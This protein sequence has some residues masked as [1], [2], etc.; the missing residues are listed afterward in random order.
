MPK[1]Y[2][3]TE[4]APAL[5]DILL[6]WQPLVN[7]VQREMPMIMDKKAPFLFVHVLGPK[8]YSP[9]AVG[10]DKAKTERNLS[11]MISRWLTEL[12]VLKSTKE[13]RVKA[14]GHERR[15]LSC[16]SFR[17]GRS[18]DLWGVYSRAEGAKKRALEDFA[19]YRRTSASVVASVYTDQTCT[20]RR[21]TR[22]G[23]E[24]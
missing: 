10:E 1:T 24:Y 13:E 14:T 18:E 17:H 23:N 5:A 21:K 3:L 16:N 22:S 12:Q 19:E 20:T 4:M 9:L 6:K 7:T 2:N 11:A 8:Q 15:G